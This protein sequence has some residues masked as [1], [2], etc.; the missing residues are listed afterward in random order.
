MLGT[1]NANQRHFLSIAQ[2]NLTRLGGLINN[3]L[4]LAKIESGKVILQKT[5][6]DIGQIVQEVKSTFEPEAKK[7]KVELKVTVARELPPV[8]ADSDKIIQVVTNLVSNALKFTPEGGRITIATSFYGTDRRFT[9][10]SV[11]DTGPGIEKGDFDR[12]FQKFSQL[13]SSVTRKVT[14]TGLGLA[15]TRE[16]VE[17]HGGK[18]WVESEKGKGSSFI[19]ILPIEAG[20]K[21]MEKNNI[22]V[23]DDEVDLCATI[24]ARLEGNGF[25]VRTALSGS[26]GLALAKENHPDLIVLDLMMP[27]MDGFAVC[28]ELK[29]DAQTT[30]IPVV[31]LTALGDDEAVK[32]ALAAGA[33]GYLMKPFETEPL[34]FTVREFLK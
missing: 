30:G 26:E 12:L 6:A 16:I 31:A 23:I 4:D 1:I 28:K 10:V 13:D 15:I 33:Q 27:G 34:L 5:L 8:P 9:Q 22:L 17:L 3:L 2:R 19:F 7:K 11:A 29:K 25:S 21:V 20:G 14:G 18:I 32:N 24:K